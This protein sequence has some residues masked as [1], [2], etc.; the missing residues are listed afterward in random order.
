M[1]GVP[2]APTAGTELAV[3]VAMS[4]WIETIVIGLEL[5][6]FAAEP[7]SEGGVRIA[8]S[9]A[10]G[11][12]DAVKDALDEAFALLEKDVP[13]HAARVRTTLV[14]FPDASPLADFEVFLD[15]AETVHQILSEAGADGVLQVATFHPVYRFGD[16]PDPDA[17]GH[18]TN[19]APY[20]VLHLLREEDVSRAV[21]GYPDIDRLPHDNVARLEALGRAHVVGLFAALHKPA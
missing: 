18:Y 11:T 20:P 5:C 21:D 15:V 12:D 9:Q 10:R 14:V 17:L 1:S 16:E 2:G 6:P 13:E 19:R 4:R 8:V 3:R 7:W